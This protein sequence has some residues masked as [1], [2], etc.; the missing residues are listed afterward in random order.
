MVI[1]LHC[2]LELLLMFCVFTVPVFYILVFIDVP[3]LLVLFMFHCGFIK[4]YM[5][6]AYM[7]VC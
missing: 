4:H 7:L 5:V 2:V 1:T 3:L 6:N